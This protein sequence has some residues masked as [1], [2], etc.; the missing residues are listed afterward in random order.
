MENKYMKC[1]YLEQFDQS[2]ILKQLP[3]PN[4]KQGEILIRVEATPIN[5]SDILM[6]QGGVYPTQYKNVPFIPGIEASGVVVQSGGGE[7]ADSLVNQRIAFF[8]GSGTYAQYAVINAQQCLLIDDDVSFNQAATSFV[9]PLTVIGMLQ[10]VN[11]AKVKAVVN[12]A[13]A[14]ALGRMMVRYFKN[15]GV[16]VINIV[17]RQEQADILKQEGATIILNQ[18]NEDFLVSLEKIT[19]QLNATIFFDAI[20]GSFTGQVLSRMPDN[21]TAYVYGLL[22]GNDCSISPRELIFKN[23]RIKGFGM[24]SWF[25]SISPELQKTSLFKLK[26]LIKSELRTEIASEQSLEQGQSA[27]QQYLDNMSSGKIILKPQL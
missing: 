12:S 20:A 18:T 15:N 1:L 19:S 14:S 11:E 9:N 26:K 6:M 16:E 27:I 4:P 23:Q 8:G 21:S 22:S 3:I 17:R 5:P 10:V 7:L 24:S 2:L 13:A 25:S